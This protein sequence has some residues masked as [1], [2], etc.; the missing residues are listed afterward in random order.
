MINYE[1]T[2]S[3]FFVANKKYCESIEKKFKTINL[4]CTGFCN[5]FGYEIE[6]TL[7]RNNQT[8][9]VKFHKHQS[10]QNGVVIPVDALEYSGMVV[11]VTGLDKKFNV[12]IGKSA[13]RRLFTLK[14]FKSKIPD[15]YFIKFN[16]S[17]DNNFVD[18]LVKRIQEE[19]ISKFKLSNGTHL[20]KIHTATSDPLD[21]I[22]DIEKMTKNWA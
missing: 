13:Y 18:D 5:A 16:Y 21:L 19:K 11:S 6:A 3:P 12:S 22:A 8:Y 9:H 7:I 4:D 17:P 15:P 20:C 1:T 10:T 14:K 2:D